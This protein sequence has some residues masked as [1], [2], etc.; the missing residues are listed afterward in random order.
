MTDEEYAQAVS[1]WTRKDAAAK[2]MDQKTL[3]AWIDTFLAA[4]KV[5]AL[6]VGGIDFIRCTPLEYTWHEGALWIF[7]EGGLKFK[8]LRENHHVAAAVFETNA[9]FGGLKSIQIEGD[10]AIVDPFTDAY[11]AAAAFRKIPLEALKKLAEPMWLLKI[12]PTEIT[13]LN[14]DFKK[15][16]FGS[17]QIWRAEASDTSQKN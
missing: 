7:T 8:G 1:F 2:K 4:H 11:N 12:V 16:G 5:L 6:A 10:A 3:Y 17:R 9:S 15:E 14:S 13:C